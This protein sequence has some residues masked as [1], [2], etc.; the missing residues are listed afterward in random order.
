[1]KVELEGS[2]HKKVKDNAVQGTP[3]TDAM[4]NAA[5]AKAQAQADARKAEQ[6]R[7]FKKIEKGADELPNGE[8]GQY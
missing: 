7:L 3:M 5:A 8:P 2:K 4:V 1:M 6:N